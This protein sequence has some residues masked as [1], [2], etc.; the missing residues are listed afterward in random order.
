M[1]F[2]LTVFL[3]VPLISTSSSDGNHSKI[4]CMNGAIPT[5]GNQ[6]VLIACDEQYFKVT[7]PNDPIPD[8]D[9]VV[10]D[11]VNIRNRFVDE[12]YFAF[13]QSDVE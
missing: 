12:D 7:E 5:P 11:R 3:L 9:G 13:F 8:L 10:S 2:L 4:G 1:R 6:T